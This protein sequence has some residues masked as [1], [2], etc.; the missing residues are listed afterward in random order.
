MAL[1]LHVASCIG[2]Y[3]HQ[4]KILAF[5]ALWLQ[6]CTLIES[7]LEETYRGFRFIFLT[8]GRQGVSPLAKLL[9][10]FPFPK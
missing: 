9:P 4:V 6:G 5:L 10:I 1:H 7:P 2:C 8:E 3:A